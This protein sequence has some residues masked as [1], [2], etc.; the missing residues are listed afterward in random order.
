MLF[1]AGRP[2]GKAQEKGGLRPLLPLAT[3]SALAGSATGPRQMRSAGLN[4]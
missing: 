1:S 3:A 4:L 2:G